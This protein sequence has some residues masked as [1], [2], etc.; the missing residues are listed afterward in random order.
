MSPDLDKFKPV[1]NPAPTPRYCPTC[2]EETWHDPFTEISHPIGT[3]PV[4]WFCRKCGANN[5]M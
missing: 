2:Q 4:I 3:N 1:A 5:G